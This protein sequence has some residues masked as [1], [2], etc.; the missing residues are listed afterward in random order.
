MLTFVFE[1]L[2][3]PL[4]KR[5][6]FQAS[7]EIGRNTLVGCGFTVTKGSSAGLE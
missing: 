5:V 1:E 7:D 3:I 2:G 4:Q 6:G